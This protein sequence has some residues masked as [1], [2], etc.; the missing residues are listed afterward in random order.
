MVQ[1]GNSCRAGTGQDFSQAQQDLLSPLNYPQGHA[2]WFTCTPASSRQGHMTSELT[3]WFTCTPP[4]PGRDACHAL[5]S[6]HK[7]LGTPSTYLTYTREGR[8]LDEHKN[9]LNAIILQ[10]K[11]ARSK[12]ASV[13]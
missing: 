3:S 2:P 5:G 6:G 10:R 7:A 4:P 9:A 1:P 8:A 12:Y 11:S 13:T